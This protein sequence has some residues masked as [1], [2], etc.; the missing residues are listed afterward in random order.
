AF[1]NLDKWNALPKP[2]QA[3]LIAAGHYAN[4]WSMAKYDAE[5]PAALKRLIASGTQLKPFSPAIMDA[6]Y[7][8][9][10]ELHNEVA[11]TNADFKKVLEA[12]RNF[13][14]D[15]YLWWQVAEYSYDSYMIRARGRG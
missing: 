6:C 8:A 4:T 5:N 3:A 14:N 9:A 12:M 15:E 10:V 1:V 2:Y 13:R 11:A 7:K